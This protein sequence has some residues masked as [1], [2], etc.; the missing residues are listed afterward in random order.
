VQWQTDFYGPPQL[1]GGHVIIDA[2]K[3]FIKHFTMKKT[4]LLSILLCV[5]YMLNAQVSKTI[6]VTTAGTLTTLLTAS[7]KSTITNLTLT[8]PMDARDVKC[9]RD[10][11]TV[12]AVV[13]M[14]GANIVAYSG[15]DG[16]GGGSTYPINEMP[17]Y[18]FGSSSYQGKASIKTV[19]L[20]YTVSSIG[21]YAF[22]G[23][24][25]LT[26]ITLPNSLT[27]IGG[28]A[29]YYCMALTSITLPNSL[30]SIGQE[31][32]Y[33]CSYLA[34]VY[35]T[36]STPPTFGADCIQST[37]KA[38]YV[39]AASVSA[40]K[41]ASGWSGLNIV[42]EKRVTINNPAAGG[43]AANI[44]GKGYG[45]LSSITHLT[46]TGNLNADDIAQMKTNM[47]NLTDINM[48][49]ATLSNNTVPVNAFENKVMLT[50]VVLPSTI[51]TIGNSAFNG[52]YNMSC[53]LPLP[54]SVTSIGSGAYAACSS[55]TGSF[56]IP[57]GVTTINDAAFNGC[58]KLN[59][60]ITIPAGVVTIGRYAFS[61][62]SGLSGSL[63]IPN[64]VTSI[65]NWAFSGCTG[66]TGALTIPNSVTSIGS[67]AF[68]NCSG[69]TGPLVLSESLT[70]INAMTFDGCT[71][72]TGTLNIP[73]AVSTIGT[74]AFQNCSGLTE[75]KIEKNISNIG[76]N[77]YNGCTGLT[78]ITV[79]RPLPPVIYS[80]TFTGVN[81]ETC[82]LVVPTG[83]SL[84]YQT[85]D[86][87]SLFKFVTE[88]NLTNSYLITVQTG[89]G[90]AIK[91][92]GNT[93]ANGT[94]LVVEENATK[95]FTIVPQAGYR[96]AMLQYG[97]VDVTAQVNNNQ[98]TTPAATADAV[99]SATFEK[100]I[101]TLA[102]Q[103]ADN[104][105]VN[106]LCEYGQTP[107]FT[108]TPL[109]WLGNPFHYL[110]W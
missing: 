74:Y 71:N 28:Y 47:T 17:R 54:A 105:T 7:E 78:Q 93:L 91:E 110:Q 50:S 41:A 107:S 9:M 18:S 33:E 57:A 85:A 106:L 83:T 89:L 80:N 43:L 20:P 87:W 48:I 55:L 39:P 19:V 40:Y 26:N 34:F 77:A 94:T 96:L 108:F 21:S 35:S 24:S 8:G 36:A 22:R 79:A 27:S 38:V 84:S 97:G 23:C 95:T 60:T 15:S 98:Y 32:F 70:S 44:I 30:T 25:G 31:T 52:C 11:M 109:H 49:D 63:T 76:D 2:I 101:Y 12:L 51:T 46:V 59:G 92:N 65:D 58:S 10:E 56:T 16:T 88:A 67:N 4:L 37:V 81:K 72:L 62:C 103:S 100:V 75:L 102:I 99:L 1:W 104:G 53:S 6:N 13:D 3:F 86:Y 61:N 68:Q 45:P 73:L 64:S 29:F 69:F 66:L 90:G 5:G 14:S 82:A 42:T